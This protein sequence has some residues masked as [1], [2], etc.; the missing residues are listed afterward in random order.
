[1]KK[2][3]EEGEGMRWR[4]WP[5]S[6]MMSSDKTRH[7]TSIL[8]L[9]VGVGV[10]VLCLGLVLLCFAFVADVLTSVLLLIIAGLRWCVVSC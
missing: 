1:M 10:G 3:G 2:I 9:G 5:S 4:L 6:S 7:D 8:E